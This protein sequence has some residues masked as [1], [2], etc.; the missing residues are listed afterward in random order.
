MGFNCQDCGTPN[1]EIVC[2]DCGFDHMEFVNEYEDWLDGVKAS[3]PFD[4]AAE[5]AH[6]HD[7]ASPEYAL[8]EAGLLAGEYG[9]EFVA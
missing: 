1:V 7:V 8:Y 6:Q 4:V 9:D 5:I 3:E 2:Y